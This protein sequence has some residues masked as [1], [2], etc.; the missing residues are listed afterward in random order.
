MIGYNYTFRNLQ[1]HLRKMGLDRYRGTRSTGFRNIDEHPIVACLGLC[2]IISSVNTHSNPYNNE[3]DILPFLIGGKADVP[4]KENFTLGGKLA[5]MIGGFAASD[6][7]T[8]PTGDFHHLAL[9]ALGD[10]KIRWTHFFSE[11]LQLDPKGIELAVF[12]NVS[13]VRTLCGG[14]HRPPSNL[15]WMNGPGRV[16]N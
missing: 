4:I 5:P 16:Y 11:H 12:W 13:L 10:T 3:R 6:T 14:V 7:P 15:F 2:Y 9:L 1:D 8:F